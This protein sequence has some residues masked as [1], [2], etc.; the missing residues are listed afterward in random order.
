MSVKKIFLILI[1]SVFQFSNVYA[2]DALILTLDNT[3]EL[4]LENS[5]EIQALNYEIDMSKNVSQ[6]AKSVFDVYINGGA[7]YTRNKQMLT[8]EDS[9]SFTKMNSYS[10]SFSKKL[11]SGT[12]VGIDAE[13]KDIDDYLYGVRDDANISISIKQ[14]LGKNFFGLEDRGLVNITNISAELSEL[15][16]FD[17]IERQISSVQKAYWFLSLQ[18][19]FV[20]INKKMYDQALELYKIYEEKKLQG[21]AEEADFLAIKANLKNREKSV[22]LSVLNRDKAKNSLL[23]LLNND[24]MTLD[25]TTDTLDNTDVKRVDIIESMNNAMANRRD[26]KINLLLARQNKIDLKLK[27]ASLWP[28]IDLAASYGANGLDSSGRHAWSNVSNKADDSFYLGISFS[29]SLNNR[30]AKANRTDAKLQ[31]QKIIAKT[32]S[33]EL[34]IISQ[35]TNSINSLNSLKTELEL[36][37]EI[38]QIQAEKLKEEEKR[39]EFGRSNVDVLVRYQDDA[40]IAEM[41]F[42]ETLYKFL[43]SQIDH[44]VYE[45]SLLSQ[46]L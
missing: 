41:K 30:A 17:S 45:N 43:A 24:D 33:N 26:Y 14:S 46:Y 7:D 23:V 35:I 2:N 38:M 22:L 28:Q 19:S 6:R 10:I 34:L 20:S 39:V 13:H 16:S 8:P 32:R 9:G 12:V 44:A 1:L 18:D 27:K 5:V 31:S 25:I 37:Q 36:S 3:V 42:Q 15:I 40:R 21:A 11:A 29:M 4:A